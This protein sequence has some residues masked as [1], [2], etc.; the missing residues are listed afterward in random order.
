VVESSRGATARALS[1]GSASDAATSRRNL[2]RRSLGVPA[3]P[4][5]GTER[6]AVEGIVG[7]GG[8][9]V[10]Y[11]AR[12]LERG[13]VVALKTILHAS[14]SAI[15]DFK[16][17]FRTLAEFSHPN[18]V[19]LH[20]L[21]H[22]AG[23]W[24]FTMELLDGTSFV[25]WI[26]GARVLRAPMTDTMLTVDGATS[27][28]VR[29][30]G[31]VGSPADL[32]PI[33]RRLDAPDE[34]RIRDAVG[35]LCDGVAAIH[36]AGKVHCD[37]KPTNVLVDKTG[38]VVVLDFGIAMEDGQFAPEGPERR[39]RGTPAYMA[40][41]Q[42]ALAPLGPAADWYAV[43]AMLYEALTGRLPFSGPW[44]AVLLAK[45]KDRPPLPSTL[46]RDVPPDLEQLCMDLLSPFPDER[47]TGSEILARLAWQPRA[48]N[49]R[50][51]AE[52]VQAPMFIGRDRERMALAEALLETKDGKL[53]T[54]FVG[55]RSGMGKSALVTQFLDDVV[56]TEP[57][58][59]VLRGRCYEREAVP[60]K[61]FDSLID[62][63][64]RHLERLDEPARASLSPRGTYGLAR[65]FPVLE[66]ALP[67]PSSA[68]IDDVEQMDPKDLRRTAFS[69]FKEVLRRLGR[70]HLV[71]LHVDDA[72]WG[73]IDSARLLEALVEPP[74]PPAVFIVLSYRSEQESTSEM[75]LETRALRG[76]RG[77][78]TMELREL[79][80]DEALAV[81][82]QLIMRGGRAPVEVARVI[83]R[84][85]GGSPFF[86]QELVHYEEDRAL[87]TTG[88]LTTT[89]APASLDEVL[90]ARI[91][92][93]TPEAQGL[94]RVLGVAG[95][96]LELDVA[97]RAADLGT[98]AFAPLAALRAAKLVRTYREQDRAMIETFH[99]R[100]REVAF[101]ALPV[102]EQR[103]LRGRLGD[104]LAASGRADHE[105][106]MRHYLAAERPNEARR[107]AILAADAASRGLAF[108]RAARLYGHALELGA[109]RSASLLRKHAD[110]LAHAGRGAAAGRA[111]LEAAAAAPKSESLHLRR[112]AAESLLKA[113]VE[114]EGVAVL[115][116][117]LTELGDSFPGSPASA[118]AGV[119]VHR[120]RLAGTSLS[121]VPR[122]ERDVSPT[123]LAR[124][125][126]AYAATIGLGMSDPLRALAFG[127]R[128]LTLALQS[129]EPFRVCRALALAAAARSAMG[130]AA[131]GPAERL[132]RA[133]ESLASTIDHPETVALARL[134]AGNVPVF[135]GEWRR[136]LTALDEAEAL[137]HERCRNV[138]WERTNAHYQ[139]S[140]VRIFL[141]EL[142]DAARRVPGAVR[143]AIERDD[144]NALSN[145]VYAVTVTHLVADDPDQARKTAVAYL[146]PSA[147]ETYTSGR[148]GS[149]VSAISVERYV[150]EGS[151]AY[152]RMTREW[153]RLER[154][155]LMRVELVRVCSWYERG[156]T[157]LA[158][159]MAG[160]AH[161]DEV[162]AVARRLAKEEPGY[163]K[164]MSLQLQALLASA[165]GN[166]P[167]A[168]RLADLAVPA[169]ERADLGYLAACA[170]ARRGALRGGMGGAVEH[171][172][173]LAWLA[174]R[175]VRDSRRCLRMSVPDRAD[176]RR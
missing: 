28:A 89:S 66:G 8:M 38:R 164:A 52:A 87:R 175:G 58:A 163:A 71:V 36:G 105:I 26:R 60:Y 23:T 122:A 27:I 95:G 150:G 145:M 48:M 72:Q 75:L 47:P 31:F 157:A 79:G 159:T 126:T 130:V 61:A 50:T 116:G 29:E 43:G 25:D 101:R 44:V 7:E 146:E 81:A 144:R 46:A 91:A 103:A 155:H 4:F 70:K 161:L 111:Y 106:V 140:S 135:F 86:V 14:P 16:R 5:V 118:L 152:A 1:G 120:A 169:L 62:A 49:R 154:S 64:T 20:E 107:Y 63:L 143:E 35:Q 39:P 12:D 160:E 2:G 109:T 99:E 65:L 34:A 18:V 127:E 134:A 129:R 9:G 21:V 165:R 137:L 100:V 56:R 96:P 166:R 53:V 138:A 41:E 83:A 73:D 94:M 13:G 32:A 15:A 113:G 115:T 153:P 156:L 37:L 80:E 114:I 84:E 136:A 151:A 54:A 98:L 11:R 170:R 141:G 148:W 17:E 123:L 102:A 117:V 3:P 85:S 6:Y 174:G 121:F 51:D 110:A 124:I 132:M 82:R 104:V 19:D 167:E 45:Q 173:A 10:V 168:L 57:R 55:G 67:P 128:Q 162:A 112:L 90:L 147:A 40:P 69:A 88:A 149:L 131:R 108:L 68:A 97:Y 133:A 24:F 77:S 93:M 176:D 142:A 92:R 171:D 119:L 139:G 30:D 76:R 172:A 22:D 33:S 42:A 74:D 158:A 78:R 125:D 59:L